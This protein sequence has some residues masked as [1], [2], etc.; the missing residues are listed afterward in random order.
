[1]QL[2]EIT[3]EIAS[4]KLTKFKYFASLQYTTWET[5][6]F[7]QSLVSYASSK[8]IITISIIPEMWLST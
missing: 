3:I 6:S 2:T 7:I 1:M 5:I 8:K 4:V